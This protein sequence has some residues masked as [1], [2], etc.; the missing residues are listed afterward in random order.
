MRE[1]HSETRIGLVFKFRKLA[2]F[3]S[4]IGDGHVRFA[5]VCKETLQLLKGLEKPFRSGKV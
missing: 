3:K 5:P 1:Y 4:R 2:N